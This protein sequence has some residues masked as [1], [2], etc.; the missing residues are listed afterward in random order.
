MEKTMTHLEYKMPSVEESREKLTYSAYDIHSLVD[1]LLPDSR[2]K[3]K[4]L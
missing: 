4:S 2:C 1:F 3:K